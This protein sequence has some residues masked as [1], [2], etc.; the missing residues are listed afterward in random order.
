VEDIHARVPAIVLWYLVIRERYG[1]F[2]TQTGG[3]ER[4]PEYYLLT[5][6][7]FAAGRAYVRLG[8]WPFWGGE[9]FE[10][11]CTN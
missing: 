3:E 11:W 2:G 9:D 1:G 4:N 10:K 5:Y 8:I 7:N 6:E